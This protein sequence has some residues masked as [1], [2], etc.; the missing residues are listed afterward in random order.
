MPGDPFASSSSPRFGLPYLAL[1]QAGKE[2]THNEA[3]ALI[4]ALLH[5]SVEAVADDPSGL[6]PEPGQCWIVGP[7]ATGEWGG[8][9]TR[10][11]CRTDGGWRFIAPV[12]GCR[13]FGSDLQ[14]DYAYD[15]TSW[16]AAPM[17]A[18]P[19]GGSVVDAEARTAIAALIAALLQAGLARPS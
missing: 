9:A 5:G 3:I 13:V 18:A 1:A 8:Q 14:A 10:I 11:A 19:S 16:V 2:I 12:P 4:D 15:G 6:D 17:L 7:G